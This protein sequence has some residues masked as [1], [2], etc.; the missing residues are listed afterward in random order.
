MLSRFA[1]VILRR[2]GINAFPILQNRRQ[3]GDV[4]PSG[5]APV[6]EVVLKSMP[7]P[8]D[9]T[10]WEDIIEFRNDPENVEMPIHMLS[11]HLKDGASPNMAGSFPT[12]AC[13]LSR[14][15]AVIVDI[16]WRFMTLTGGT[17][18]LGPSS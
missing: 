11:T 2:D 8:D 4:F 1:S 15:L 3:I 18:P 9:E 6:L 16:K 12:A 13:G 5:G 14:G 10:P 7:I 17:G